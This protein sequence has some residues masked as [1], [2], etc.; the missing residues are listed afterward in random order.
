MDKHDQPFCIVGSKGK[1][2]GSH[3]RHLPALETKNHETELEDRINNLEAISA[4]PGQIPR[5]YQ[6]KI[7]QLQAKVLYLGNKL[8]EH[9]DKSKTRQGVE[10]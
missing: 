9:I 6:Y 8:N 1:F 2:R 5:Q 3:F 7:E 10:L 4:E